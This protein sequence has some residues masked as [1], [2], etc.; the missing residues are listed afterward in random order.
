[1]VA[2]DKLDIECEFH[3]V[4]KLIFIDQIKRQFAGEEMAE[5]CIL[6]NNVN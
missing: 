2:I 4:E 5:R 3:Y 1:M 6:E